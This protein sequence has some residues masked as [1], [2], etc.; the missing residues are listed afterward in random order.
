MNLIGVNR[1]TVALSVATNLDVIA[2]WK[3]NGEPDSSGTNTKITNDDE[4][5]VVGAPGTG[6]RRRVTDLNLTLP[7]SNSQGCR[8]TVNQTDGTSTWE[9]TSADLVPG[10]S[11]LYDI[12]RGWHVRALA[13][14][15]NAMAELYRETVPGWLA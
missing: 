12:Q 1:L 13:L 4:G 5:T 10:D 8:I 15:G 7:R 6:K 3:D 2:S 9:V 14:D 11:L